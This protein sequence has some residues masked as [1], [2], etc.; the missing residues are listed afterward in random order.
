MA[1][2]TVSFEQVRKG[3]QEQI[4]ARR[5]G[6]TGK[7]YAGD[8][9]G[10]AFSGGGIR[11]GTLNLGITQGLAH[12]GMLPYIDYLS[13]VSGG[14]YIGTWLHGVIKRYGDGK[15]GQ[16]VLDK[17]APPDSAPPPAD[18]NGVIED[19][20]YFLRKYSSYLAPDVGLFSADFWTI[21]IIWIRNTS[22]NQMILVS[23][24]ALVTL[25]MMGIG[26]LSQL[27]SSKTTLAPKVIVSV[28]G[29][30]LACYVVGRG[31]SRVVQPGNC[32]KA[33]EPQRN[34]YDSIWWGWIVAA[35][36]LMISAILASSARGVIDWASWKRLLPAI[37]GVL[38]FLFLLLQAT[39]GFWSCCWAR[40]RSTFW[41]GLY[42]LLFPIVAAAVTGCLLYGAL[43]WIGTWA[44]LNTGAASW[45][46]IAFGPAL[47]MMVWLKGVGL[48]IGLMGIDYP[49]FGR[50]WLSRLGA[51]LFIAAFAWAGLFALLIFGPW[52]MTKL[53]ISFGKTAGALGAGWIL[54]TAAGVLAGNSS[55][56]GRTNGN[57]KNQSSWLDRIAKIAPTVFMIG[58]LIVIGFAVHLGV[59]ALTGPYATAAASSATAP[60]ISVNVGGV[61]PGTDVK[62][63]Y[64]EHPAFSQLE[65][66][67]QFAQQYWDVDSVAVALWSG[68]VVF[69]YRGPAVFGHVLPGSSLLALSL[70]C[71]LVLLLIGSRVNINEFSLHHFYKNRLVRCYLGASRG[72]KRKGSR[73][74]GFDPCDDFPLANLLAV[75]EERSDNQTKPDA[76]Y[77]PFPILN[78]TLN[79]NR[80]SDMAR[81]ERKGT[82]FVFTPLYSGYEPPVSQ[83]DLQ[84]VNGEQG[85]RKTRGYSTKDGWDIGTIMAISGAAANPNWGFSTSASVA[86]L[87]TVFDV[88]LGWWVG[89]TRFDS[90]SKKPGPSFA[91]W[92]L[93]NELFA[94]T[95]SRSSFLNLSDG[96]HFEN[97]GVYELVRRR[98]KYII[99][100]DGEQ[101]GDYTFESLGGVIR[102][103]RADFGVEIDID[104]RRIHPKNG[105]STT[106]CVVG[107]IHY[108]K[109]EGNGE[110]CG[111]LLYLK[112]SLTGDEP[113]DVIQYKAGHPQFPQDPT[114]NQFFTESQFESYRRLGL[115][116]VRSAFEDFE[117]ET[118]ADPSHFERVFERLYN[119]W[120]PPIAIEDGA[121]TR[122]AERYSELMKRLSDDKDLAYLD[123]QIVEQK[124]VKVGVAAPADPAI[125]RKAFFYCLELIQLM[126]NV[127][128]DL[129]FSEGCNRQNP[130]HRGWLKIFEFWAQQKVFEATWN[131]ASNMFNPLFQEFF[132]RMA[133]PPALEIG[134]QPCEG[135][136]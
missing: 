99:V 79:I 120:H 67:N 45:Y 64:D 123:C 92:P 116:I 24:L 22:L 112:S 95:D 83:E 51:F 101:D 53:I 66:L 35:L 21:L 49:D 135:Y 106:H 39:S 107:R 90:P 127:W 129:H 7:E 119:K 104:P 46:V 56:T 87:L 133:H 136:K 113:E 128:T 47:I 130:N 65:K 2:D 131:N 54:T 76:Y 16:K 134:K 29:L 85:Y 31:V 11:S 102:K 68:D 32:D 36:M 1:N 74:T 108:P 75:P 3:E 23:A 63:S 71:F 15:P 41:C 33:G 93:L 28:L 58:Y 52:W 97:F 70:G 4:A 38:F 25:A 111:W 59:R 17:L 121:S 125:E 27:P 69:L 126:E 48:H 103:C 124:G 105:F 37:I 55:R 9:V 98:V 30:A 91:L 20:I 94:Q 50:E 84:E 12:L 19:P 43:W 40:T 34:R 118:I 78:T 18:S 88:R 114:P 110:F 80:G 14:G 117:N 122:H 62:I 77:G 72:N 115:H 8:S 42:L 109:I 96:G 6:A 44:A 81:Q 61:P 5:K 13:T 89:N 60:A 86:F 132:H 26:F 10:L 82:S 57:E 73:M 100:G